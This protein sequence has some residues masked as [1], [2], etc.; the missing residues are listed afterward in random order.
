M[1]RM[2]CFTSIKGFVQYMLM[3]DGISINQISPPFR[4]IQLL[5]DQ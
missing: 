4:N 5:T 3:T 2:L 1:A